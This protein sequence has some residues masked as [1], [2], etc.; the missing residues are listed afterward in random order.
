M[1]SFA[2]ISRLIKTLGRRL[3]QTIDIE[4]VILEGGSS[5]VPVHMSWLLR[6]ELKNLTGLTEEITKLHS[7]LSKHYSIMEYLAD[8]SYSDNDEYKLSPRVKAYLL[9]KDVSQ[10]PRV[11]DLLKDYK[12]FADLQVWAHM[13][14]PYI[15]MLNGSNLTDEK[16]EA[17]WKLVN[18]EY[19]KVIDYK[20]DEVLVQELQSQFDQILDIK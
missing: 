8:G 11:I 2:E 16:R 1:S 12:K 13:F 10:R 15:K 18:Q 6:E 14:L 9:A 3:K 5:G 7:S 20:S 19:E 4:E 17:F